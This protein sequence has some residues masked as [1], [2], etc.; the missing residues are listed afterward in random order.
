MMQGDARKLKIKIR[1]ADGSEV[2]DADISDVE[3]TVGSMRKTLKAGEL[4]FADDVFLFPITQ[5]ES[6]KLPVSRVKAQVRVVWPNGDVQGVSLGH[7]DIDESI[8]REVLG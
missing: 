4:S 8:S 2:T 6:F 7:I 3:I 1:K 5:Q